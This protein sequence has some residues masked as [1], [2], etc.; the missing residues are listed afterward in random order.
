MCQTNDRFVCDG[1]IGPRDPDR[2][3]GGDA[4]LLKKTAFDN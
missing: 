4:R 1:D 2:M 3:S